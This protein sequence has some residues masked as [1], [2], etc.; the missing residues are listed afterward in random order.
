MGQ[1]RRMARVVAL[2]LGAGLV[3][4]ACGS[5]NSKSS[6]SATTGAAT[7]G[8]ATTSAA[9][10][11]AATSSAATTGA[12]TSGGG[13]G[14]AAASCSTA[15]SSLDAKY[16]QNA[17]QMAQILACAKD[18]PLKAD[19]SLTP[20]VMGL[21]NS[22]GDPSF[23]FPDI[24][25]GMQA[26]VNY[27]NDNLGGIGGDP[28]KGK[29]G[30]PI[31]LETCF[32][33]LDPSDSVRCANELAGKKPA[34][35]IQGFNNNSAGTYPVLDGAGVVNI[36]GIPVNLA[37]Y[38]AKG[39][40]APTPGGGCVGA[41]PALV[42]YAVKQLKAKSVAVA[43]FDVPNGRICYHDLEKKPLNILAGTFDGPAGVKGSVPD[44]KNTGV[45]IPPSAPDLTTQATQILDSKP[46]AILYSAP[47]ASCVSLINALSGLGWSAKTAPAVFTG[48]C[49]DQQQMEELG[50]K[51]DGIYFVSAKF[52][53]DPTAYEDGLLKTES[54]QFVAAMKQYA[55]DVMVSNF[56]AQ[57]FQD[58]LFLWQVISNA[59]A[60]VG[61]D[62]LDHDTIVNAIGSTVN[63]HE[64]A[65][66]PVSCGKSVEG[67]K[68]I[69]NTLNSVTQ[70]DAASKTRKPVADAVDGAYIIAGTKLDPSVGG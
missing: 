5:D 35:V 47:A 10:S 11:A 13:G 26:A 9:T 55:P 50:D 7:S 70:W 43:Y 1:G 4:A 34:L 36:A 46:N 60:K 56:T 25:G 28:V 58:T 19:P 17:G 27:I 63:H 66:S 16:G 67:Y 15:D 45:A 21:E 33:G 57:V 14:G 37:D 49:F 31:K 18:K 65:A 44:L 23:T 53:G 61:V 39:V 40:Y 12:A 42:E 29:A 52:A 69:C 3:A 30:R 32:I 6:G 62:K 38:N 22:Q 8:A 20:F 64:W 2:L 59:A 48:A 41:H 54:E 24:T 51:A 68:S